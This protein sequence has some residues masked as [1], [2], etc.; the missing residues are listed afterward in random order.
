MHKSKDNV[1][2]DRKLK[3]SKADSQTDTHRTTSTFKKRYTC[4]YTKNVKGE[5][6]KQATY[7]KSKSFNP[8][9]GLCRAEPERGPFFFIYVLLV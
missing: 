9:E 6:A 1:T 4:T 8:P 3:E 7:G 2:R 5:E